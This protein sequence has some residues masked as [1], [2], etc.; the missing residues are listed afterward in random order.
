MLKIAFQNVR[1]IN[2]EKLVRLCKYLEKVDVIFMSEVDNASF[3]FLDNDHFKY[4]YDPSSCRRIAMLASNL[5]DIEPVGPGIRLTQDRQQKDQTAAQSYLYK[6]S[7]T[8]DK[9]KHTIF[10][11]NFYVIPALSTVNRERLHDF[12]S[13]RSLKY[14]NFV[15]GGDMNINWLVAD[16]REQFESVGGLTQQV[17]EYTRSCEFKQVVNGV[18]VKKKT[19]S[20]IDLIFTSPALKTSCKKV[21][22]KSIPNNIGDKSAK[23]DHKAAICEFSFSNPHYYREITYYPNPHNRPNPDEKQSIAICNEIS[24]IDENK[25]TSY[26]D[27]IAKTTSI[28][29]KFIPNN[30]PG[31]KTK[32]LYRF[33][34]MKSIIPEIRLKH[35]MRGQCKSPADWALYR[36]QCNKVTAL[37]REGKKKFQ[38]ELFDNCNSVKEINSTLKALESNIIT[39]ISGNSDKLEFEIDNVK[40]SGQ[41]LAEKAGEFYEKRA[42]GLVTDLEIRS[43]GRPG[44]V[45]K[46]DESLP[47][48]DFSF[49]RFEK[50]NDF[51]PKNK[52]TNQAGPEGFSSSILEIIWPSFQVKLNHVC[53]KFPLSYPSENQ[54]YL[55]R[56]IPKTDNPKICKDLRPI[57]VL[58]PIPKYLF[59]GPFFKALRTHLTPI[60]K[61][62]NNYSYLGT[63]RCIIRSLDHIMAQVRKGLPTLLVKYDFSNAFGTTDPETVLSAFSQLN[64]SDDCINYIRG[65]VYNQASARTIISDKTGYFTSNEIAMSRGN[66]QGQIGADLVFLVQQLVLREVENV[67]RTIYV[68]DLNDVISTQKEIDTILTAIRNEVALKEQVV[69]VGFMLNA[70]KTKYIPFNIPDQKLLDN[71]IKNTQIERNTCILGFPFKATAGGLDVSPATEMVLKRLRHKLLSVHALRNYVTDVLVLVKMAK[72]LIFHCI[73]E[74]HL[75][76]GYD[77]TSETNFNKI[78]VLVNKILRATGLRSTTPCHIL[79]R[80][81]G[82]SLK[83]FALQGILVNGLKNLSDRP[84]LFHRKDKIQQEREFEP[85]TYM[86]KFVKLWNDLSSKER[87]EILKRDKKTKEIDFNFDRI[88][89]LLK[90][91]RTLEYATSIHTEYKWV[92]YSRT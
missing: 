64:L 61:K 25:L 30:A 39:N 69:Q 33:P 77:T 55:Q 57:G 16:N 83:D 13:D 91:K 42:T 10:F 37:V 15:L 70:G 45:L 1:T 85:N 90:K 3:R 84:E 51:I 68:D 43:A 9:K 73:G 41:A 58:N 35:R 47:E 31:A 78:R 60:F 2:K 22:T 48:F 20:I 28:L 62:R 32:K 49:P 8:K 81:F 17:H 23:F 19:N 7:T 66:P 44:P 18:E 11:E 80:V 65:Y 54:G 14:P 29:D 40:Y 87:R 79:D 24:S 71:D 75:I 76:L 88:K 52:I 72:T 26:D 6:I 5:I 53:Q 82:T 12:I 74:V 56:T 59:N 63:H 21:H 4:H 46:F 36:K 50:L 89:N 38:N 67:L 86:H 34:W 27:L 92:D